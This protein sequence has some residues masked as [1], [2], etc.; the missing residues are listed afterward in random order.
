M[1]SEAKEAR[2]LKDIAVDSA[3][4]SEISPYKPPAQAEIAAKAHQLTLSE[5]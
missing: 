2:N 4:K 5:P 3:R 1:R